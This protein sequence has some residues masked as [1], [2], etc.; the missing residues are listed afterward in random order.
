[1]ESQPGICAQ[2]A[3]HTAVVISDCAKMILLYPS[4]LMIPFS[5]VHEHGAA[6]L[7]VLFICQQSH[8]ANFAKIFLISASV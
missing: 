6:E 8:A 1:M 5:K 2:L 3:G 7:S 4:F